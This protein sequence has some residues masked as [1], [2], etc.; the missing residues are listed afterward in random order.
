MQT[1]IEALFA[2]VSA[3]SNQLRKGDEGDAVQ[4]G[5]RTILKILAEDGPLTVPEMARVRSTSRQNIQILVNRLEADGSVELASNPAHQRSALVRITDPGRAL[6]NAAKEE[7]GKTMAK[8]SPHISETELASATAT[9][10][11]M[12][13]LLA[14]PESQPQTV[15]R[16]RPAL[17][18]EMWRKKK[19]STLRVAPPRS[20]AAMVA[21]AIIPDTKKESEEDFPVN[22]L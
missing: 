10:R 21:E 16:D 14:A 1:S 17:K 13:N 5:G 7:E 4:S 3:L 22:L 20:S 12:R 6:L 9:L 8:I 15:R 11:R 18:L 2:E 19:G